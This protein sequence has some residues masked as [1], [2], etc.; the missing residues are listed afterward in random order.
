VNFYKNLKIGSKV[1]LACSLILVLAVSI[2][3]YL[4]IRV[5]AGD[6]LI[7][8][9]YAGPYE[10]TRNCLTARSE[11]FALG[12]DVTDGIIRS[13]QEYIRE[14]ILGHFS[15]IDAAIEAMEQNELVDGGTELANFKSGIAKYKSLYETIYQTTKSADYDSSDYM[16]MVNL[17]KEF[18]T[19]LRETLNYAN[20]LYN[21][22]LSVDDVF[23]TESNESIATSTTIGI[24]LMIIGVIAVLI[25][26]TILRKSLVEPLTEIEDASTCMSNGDFNVD[27]K[28]TSKD[29]LGNLSESIRVLAHRTKDVVNDTVRVLESFAE[30]NFNINTKSEYIGVFK[31]VEKSIEKIA[32]D[33]SDTMIQ[34]SS[35]SDEVESASEQV[36]SGSQMLAQ[37]ATEQASSVQELSAT[38]SEISK[39]IKHTAENASHA[40]VL[41]INAGKEVNKGNEQ[42]AQ[43]VKAMNEISFTSNE[44]GRIIKTIDDIAFQTNILALNAAVEAAR[45]GS[46]GKGF[47][48]VA[49]E[50]RNL[51]AKSAEAAKNT[52]I[53]IENSIQAVE[54]G[55]KIV[56]NTAQSLANIIEIT[57]QTM[58][59]VEMI[60][61]A[62]DEQASAITQVAQGVE[63]ISGVVQTNSATAQESAAASEELSSQAQI[64]KSLIS[65][66]KVRGKKNHRSDD[67]FSK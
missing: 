12:K 54:N 59:S 2:C 1:V 7:D 48:V 9:L 10:F 58:N 39:K 6:T 38:L 19:T 46:A 14:E 66:F 20:E 47:A 55:T 30:G 11:M 63:Q 34:I 50:V 17:S 25:I 23:M 49:D 4:L 42:M 57:N 36:S 62:S 40:N 15:K 51:A 44:I 56:N 60:A 67:Y 26:S 61:K 33:L 21:K 29:E 45:A 35:A 16:I 13:D 65:R 3:A 52:A 22:T 41:T 31:G 24:I 8:N 27:V 64:L 28:Y 53:L 43:M 32:S 18:D 37:G 5:K